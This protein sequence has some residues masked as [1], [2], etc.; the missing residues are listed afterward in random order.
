M[1]KSNDAIF[2]DLARLRYFTHETADVLFNR[3]RWF[4]LRESSGAL[5]EPP[6]RNPD[7]IDS[8]PS[9]PDWR[10]VTL[11][12]VGKGESAKE[13][14][15]AF[16]PPAL[17][18][19]ESAHLPTDATHDILQIGLLV[20]EAFYPDAEAFAPSLSDVLAFHE[21]F[22][23]M[24]RPFREHEIENPLIERIAQHWPLIS[25]QNRGN[26]DDEDDYRL[27]QGRWAELLKVPVE[28]NF[29]D[30]GSTCA[31]LESPDCADSGIHPAWAVNADGRAHVSACILVR[32]KDGATGHAP[33]LLKSPLD[34]VRRFGK[35]M[36][37]PPGLGYWRRLL[38][39]D[40]PPWDV[41]EIHD[42]TEFERRWLEPRTYL[43]WA[44]YGTAYGFT[45]HSTMMLS[46]PPGKKLPP[47]WRHFGQ[48]YFDQLALML[49][50]RSALFRFSRTLSDISSRGRH[51]D[52]HCDAMGKIDVRERFQALRKEFDWFTN[53]YRFPL[54]SSEQQAVEMFEK[55]KVALDVEALHNEVENEVDGTHDVLELIATQ[56]F[57]RLAMMFSL[58]GLF[59]L[60]MGMVQTM[61]AFGSV[62]VKMPPWTTPMTLVAIAIGIAFVLFLSFV[63]AFLK[64]GR[65][66][67]AKLSEWIGVRNSRPA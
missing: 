65:L 39:V 61:L 1:A 46:A 14:S 26:D 6:T 45:D 28:T 49:Y 55:L 48:M 10:R 20:F 64:W 37:A 44:E 35:R 58:L 2:L 51:S 67:E 9:T 50:V 4:V 47:T 34:P 7:R 12:R 23:Y 53:L 30:G 11:P 52:A 29:D 25:P 36:K 13:Y 27:Y 63:F 40:T 15:V 66:F 59:G 31:I 17:V 43:R 41:N 62:P 24:R 21:A 18:L 5:A 38:N 19:F 33:V 32:E 60:V 3:A 54:L 8:P 22:R 16:R 57:T 56:Q 42:N